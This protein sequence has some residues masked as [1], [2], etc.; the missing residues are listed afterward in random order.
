MPSA[1]IRV[2]GGYGHLAHEEDPERIAELIF[3][4]V[5]QLR[6]GAPS[7]AQ[8]SRPMTG[9]DSIA[10]RLSRAVSDLPRCLTGEQPRGDLRPYRQ[11]PLP[12]D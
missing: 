1:R 10:E 11:R 12:T 6:A 4:A 3:D 5:A 8:A 7:E 2:V 9:S